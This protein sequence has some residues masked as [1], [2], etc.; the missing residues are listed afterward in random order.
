[1]MSHDRHSHLAEDPDREYRFIPRIIHPVRMNHVVVF[2]ADAQV[3]EAANVLDESMPWLSAQVLSNPKSVMDYRTEQ[4]SVFVLDDTALNI[5]DADRI[6]Q[7]NKDAVVVLV[8]SNPFIHCSP[9]SAAADKYA[10][11]TKADLVFA[12]DRGEFAPARILASVVRSA[13]DLLNIEKYSKAKAYIFLI[14]DD[15][16]RWFSQFL[17][18]LYNIIGQRA[19]V[20]I[21]RTYEETLRFL[22]GV[23]RE[24]DIDREHY[25][26]SGRGDD[27]VC[28]ITDIFFP[29][30]TQLDSDA[31]RDLVRLTRKYYP[32]YPIIIASKAK[33]AADL[34]DVAFILPKGDPGSLDKLR[35]HIL[36]FTGMG[37]FLIC[38]HAGQEIYRV[39]TIHE[40]HHL[41]KEA[42][43]DDEEGRR[44]RELLEVYGRNDRFSAWLYMH[45][46]RELADTLRPKRA[47]GGELVMMLK[48]HL[49][50]EIEK[51]NHIPLVVDGNKIFSLHDLLRSLETA[52]PG[53]I[54]ELSDSDTF[55]SWLDR[56][57]Y[58]E[59]A[60][61][62]R[63]IHGSGAGLVEALAEGI[64]RWI[65]VYQERNRL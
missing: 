29:K 63:P 40:M 12:I 37:D 15:E 45:S 62:L 47:E 44:L 21:T 19:D 18:L 26:S 28:V 13:E 42:E 16:P 52:A 23:E 24:S 49:G 56:K 43:N 5:I 31:G 61:E 39:K 3:R 10:Y 33:E 41:L 53:Q 20:M 38:D 17:P 32:R 27:V 7:N 58:P 2:S 64:A 35:D 1:M 6:R 54:Q 57:G 25:R 4:A 14:V 51:I 22:F 60:D 30:G 34:S 8:S 65:Q 48:E 55:S 36:D 9:P 11:T 59:L 50:M 46:Y